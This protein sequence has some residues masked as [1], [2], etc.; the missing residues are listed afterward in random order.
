[1]RPN[2]LASSE[3]AQR[4]KSL[5]GWQLIDSTLQK[6]FEFKN[7]KSAFSFMTRI[8]FAAEKLNHHPDWGNVYNRV[9]ISLSTN[10]VGGITELDFEL[11]GTITKIFKNGF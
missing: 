3:I 10:D 6:K 9:S 5:E 11:A 2:L 4:M 8:A 1:M 7:F